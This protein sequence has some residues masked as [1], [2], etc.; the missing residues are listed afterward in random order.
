M[1]HKATSRN[2]KK[3]Q[4]RRIEQAFQLKLARIYGLDASDLS[5]EAAA[6]LKAAS[7]FHHKAF[8][9]VDLAKNPQ[10]Y[11][12]LSACAEAAIIGV[13][14]L[15]KMK[16]HPHEHAPHAWTAEKSGVVR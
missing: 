10:E 12:S 14:D 4:K 6:I 13:F 9:I 11:A 2:A 3:R 5:H 15:K 1:T 16:A 7:S 8:D